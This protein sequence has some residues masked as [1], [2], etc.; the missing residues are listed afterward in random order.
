MSLKI[1]VGPHDHVQGST[2]APVVLVEYGDYQCPACGGVEP[3]VK[4]LRQRFGDGLCLVFRNFPLSDMHPQA[5]P[6]AIVAEV[7]ARHGR[8]WEAHDVLYANQ[9][10]LGVE[11]Y[12]QIAQSLGISADAL[13]TAMDGGPE[14]RRIEADFE[15]G[16]RSGVNGTPCFF[17]NGQRFVPQAGFEEL[18]DLIAD[19]IDGQAGPVPG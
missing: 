6:A 7:A 17:V 8:F 15:G 5:L 14:A 3:L 16:I 18:F 9:N 2:H 1:P 19:M 13:S 11:L 12:Q 10:V 4:R